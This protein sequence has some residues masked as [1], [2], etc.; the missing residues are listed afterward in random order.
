MY[1]SIKISSQTLIFKTTGCVKFTAQQYTKYHDTSLR[2]MSFDSVIFS[3]QKLWKPD[4][5]YRLITVPEILT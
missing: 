2:L 5:V 3:I 4:W 1:V